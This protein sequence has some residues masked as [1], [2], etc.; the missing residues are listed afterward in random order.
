MRG[1]TRTGTGNTVAHLETRNFV[2]NRSH[3]SRRAVPESRRAVELC[4]D[5]RVRIQQSFGTSFFDHL[6]N[7]IG[8]LAGLPDQAFLAQIDGVLFRPRA[9]QRCDRAYEKA[10]TLDAG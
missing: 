5:G 3:N 4:F 2:A 10:T 9:N 1:V 7:Q 6:L 8:A